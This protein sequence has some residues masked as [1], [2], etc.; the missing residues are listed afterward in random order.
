[1]G[2]CS[3]YHTF[4]IYQKKVIKILEMHSGRVYSTFKGTLHD[5]S[6]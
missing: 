5:E 6:M 3:N 4:Q 2:A 1:M